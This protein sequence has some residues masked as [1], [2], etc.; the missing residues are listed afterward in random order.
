MALKLTTK[1]NVNGVSSTWP[2]GDVR[3]KT[4][5]IDGTKWDKNQMSDPIQ[6]FEKLMDIAGVTHNNSFD[7]FDNGFQLIEALLV[8]TGTNKKKTIEIGI[9]DMDAT[10]TV[11]VAHGLV[12]KTKIRSC[13]AVILDD[14]DLVTAFLE[15]GGEGAIGLIDDTNISLSRNNGGFFDSALYNDGVM[16]RG[17]ITIEYVD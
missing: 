12:D 15:L 3:N 17:F 1:T 4:L 10:G 9:W 7:N 8:L 5:G 2:F 14:G 6:F 11:A 13:T 16:N